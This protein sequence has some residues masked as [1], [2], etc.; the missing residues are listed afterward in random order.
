MFLDTSVSEIEET[1]KGF[2]NRSD[3][4]IILINQVVSMKTF[5][6]N[7]PLTTDVDVLD[8]SKRQ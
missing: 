1:F 4:A 5:L 2:T 6:E 3:I 7:S 8:E